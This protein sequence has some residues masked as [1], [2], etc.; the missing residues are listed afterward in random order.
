MIGVTDVPSVTVYNR[1]QRYGEAV[2]DGR[3][4]HARSQPSRMS[5]PV[6]AT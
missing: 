6:V 2:T 1:F 4:A 3:E 5:G